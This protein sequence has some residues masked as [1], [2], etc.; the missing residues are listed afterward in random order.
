[1]MIG[2]K[3]SRLLI[4]CVIIVGG[5]FL[6]V[7]KL[8]VDNEVAAKKADRTLIIY[9][10]RTGNTKAV[11]EIIQQQVGGKLIQLKTKQARPTIYRQEV[12]QN[13][14]EQ[15]N[16]VLPELAT[17]ITDFSK[18]DRIFIGA[19]TW[20]MALPQAVVTFLDSYDFKDKTVIPFN[21]NGGYGAGSTFR[22]IKTLAKGAKVLEGYS[23][24][25]GE[26]IYGR[27]LVIKGSYK[28]KVSNQVKVW[29]RKIKQAR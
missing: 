4:L 14:V 17:K 24:K 27:N 2:K 7:N 26:E 23:V 21:T 15:E 12:E 18:Y 8:I 5:V 9:Y 20:N 11:A 25:G 13:V 16:N 3:K 28:T 10:S 29:L 6:M 19:P 1:M 22:Q